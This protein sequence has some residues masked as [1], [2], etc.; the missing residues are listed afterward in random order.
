MNPIQ[1]IDKTL[2]R[3]QHAHSRSR[4]PESLAVDS[5]PQ[6]TR[7]CSLRIPISHIRTSSAKWQRAHGRSGV[8]AISKRRAFGSASD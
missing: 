8:T 2:G 1:G 4:T 5:T 6:P 3:M 7:F